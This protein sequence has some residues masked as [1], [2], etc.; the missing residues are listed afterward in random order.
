MVHTRTARAV[1]FERDPRRVVV[2][3]IEVE[4]LG[5]SD[6]LVAAKA[7][8]LCRS[9]NELLDGH[10]DAQLAVP[11]PV[12]PG[13]EWAGEVVA[14]GGDV[15]NVAVGDRVV[16]ECVIAPNHW[17]GFTY[18][19]AASELFRVPSVLLHRLPDGVDYSSG[20]LVEPFTIAY[21]A[22]RVS[23]GVDASDVVAIVGGGMIGQCALAV[24]HGASAM[25]MVIEPN[26]VRRALAVTMGADVVVDPAK[27]QAGDVLRERFGADG[28]DLV[29]EASGHPSGL[30]S[31]LR[32]ARH[33]GRVTNIGICAQ[34]DVPGAWG[35]IQAKDLT[36]RGTT[37]SSGV[38]PAALRFLQ[39]NS[40]DLRPTI[41]AT[42]P[43]EDAAV[44]MKAT[45]DPD[46]VKVHLQF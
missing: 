23:G 38:W 19:G 14:V 36:V 15:T 17:F 18:H 45:D 7:V 44:A 11:Y 41:T 24:A 37:G 20:A 22:V 28:A 33:A 35:L 42:V 9:D 3:D 12:V 21:N 25:T 5:R 13:H 2:R 4:P 29:I 43:F 6:V 34:H 46:N 26:P 30:A 31:T 16:G 8:G 27:E 10:L 39:R 40:I 1:V 32:I